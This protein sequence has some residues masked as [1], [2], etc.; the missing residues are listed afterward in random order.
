MEHVII[1]QCIDNQYSLNIEIYVHLKVKVACWTIQFLPHK[2]FFHNK[3]TMF[4]WF[5]RTHFKK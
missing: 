2:F 4:G 1:C 5:M 3:A